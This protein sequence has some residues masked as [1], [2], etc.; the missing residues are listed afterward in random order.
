MSNAIITTIR[1]TAGLFTS[2]QPRSKEGEE[3]RSEVF[4]IFSIP[5]SLESIANPELK[6]F[7]V[8]AYGNAVNSLLRDAVKAGQA[9]FTIPQISEL[10]AETKREF[11]ITKPELLNWINDFALMLISSAI[12]I[13]AG[14]HIDSP[15]VVKKAI[16][17]R[18]LL[19]LIASRSIMMQ[20]QLDSCL[21][22]MELVM[23]S[24]K[25]NSYSDNVIQAIARKQEKLNEYLS[26]NQD[27]DDEIDF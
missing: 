12:S 4:A 7:A 11:L 1:P 24:G 20:E 3:K 18:E 16:A 22:V 8:R 21:K 10:Y 19:L 17:Y 15:K 26:G 2:F 9:E 5:A 13:K 23:A 27:S 6:G 14:L 25:E